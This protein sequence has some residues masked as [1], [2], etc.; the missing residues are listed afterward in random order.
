MYDLSCY[1]LNK[2]LKNCW[3]FRVFSEHL[4]VIKMESRFLAVLQNC[5][6]LNYISSVETAGIKLIET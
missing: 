3:V 2:C 1:K 5:L 6:S 4:N